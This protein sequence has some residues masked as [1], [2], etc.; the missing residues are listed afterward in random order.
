MQRF[1]SFD[2]PLFSKERYIIDIGFLVAVFFIYRGFFLCQVQLPGLY[3]DEVDKLVLTVALLTG[4]RF[5]GWYGV[6]PSSDLEYSF[7]LKKPLCKVVKES[8]K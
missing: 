4:Q 5:L 3:G 1:Q 6:R 2:R 7:H 8:T